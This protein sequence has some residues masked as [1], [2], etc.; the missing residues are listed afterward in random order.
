MNKNIF[1]S[2]ILAVALVFGIVGCDN[3]TTSS[4]SGNTGT[5]APINPVNVTQL[6]NNT[7]VTGNITSLNPV[8]WY[9]INV[10]RGTKYYVW[11]EY[12]GNIHID[13]YIDVPATGEGG[14]G[15][16]G[17]G[18]GGITGGGSMEFTAYSDGTAYFK[19]F[20]DSGDTGNYTIVYNTTGIKP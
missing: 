9:S 12:N 3:G 13:H 7:K 6:V 16:T 2:V 19:V 8:I 15:G 17:G 14:G 11:F 5:N 18:S 1:F 10:V 4:G 20:L